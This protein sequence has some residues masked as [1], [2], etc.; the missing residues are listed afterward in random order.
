[1]KVKW[2]NR[3]EWVAPARPARAL[4]WV[5][6]VG[7]LGWLTG[8]LLHRT[9]S[10]ATTASAT[11][12]GAT[13]SQS[14]LTPFTTSGWGVRDGLGLA[15]LRTSPAGVKRTAETALWLGRASAEELAEWWPAL[16]AEKPQDGG[17]LDLVMERWMELAPLAALSQLA[18]SPEEFRAWWA[19]GKVDPGT[20]MKQAKAFKSGHA[21]RVLQGAGAGDPLT[22]IRLVEEHPALGNSTVEQAIIAG[23]QNLG[24]RDSLTYRFSSATLRDWAEH[25]PDR[26]FEWALAHA[27]K[28]DSDTWTR[29]IENLNE[30]DP[31]QVAQTLASVPSGSTRE[32][33]LLAQAAWIAARDLP[34]ALVMVE[35]AESPLLRNRML[36]R[37]GSNLAATDPVRSL[38]LFREVLENGGEEYARRV[39]RPDGEEL[40]RTGPSATELWLDQLMV[41]DPAKVMEITRAVGDADLEDRARATWLTRDFNG[42]SAVLCEL[43]EGDLRD[44]ELDQVVGFLIQHPLADQPA[45]AFPQTLEWVAA[46]TQPALRG[47]RAREVIHA[48]L[49][50]DAE[51]AAAFCADD[52]EATAEERVAYHELKGGAQ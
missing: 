44:H 28:V 50:R 51:S 52:G 2:R 18:G 21:W 26:A 11:G 15:T 49:Q 5:V 46:I 47:K 6:L 19:W 45:E 41:Q 25:E 7:G 30:S 34:A 14:N 48:W 1:M 17:L 38:D 22:A 13:G 20:A 3:S 4:V 8:H 40:L 33:L 24:W 29:L 39:V 27:S 23:L 31:A 9:I 35:G 12:G 42:Y 37:I 10:A 16:A 36:T 32:H 43:P